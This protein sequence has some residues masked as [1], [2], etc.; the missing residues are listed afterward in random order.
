MASAPSSSTLESPG[1]IQPVTLRD[2]VDNVPAISCA[3]LE[4]PLMLMDKGKAPLRDSQL[5]GP[6]THPGLCSVTNVAHTSALGDPTLGGFRAH[7]A[8]S[9]ALGVP[10][11]AKVT[12]DRALYNPKSRLTVLS[13]IAPDRITD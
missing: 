13:A 9:I 6:S 1:R 4:P 2:D 10:L 7:P 3:P 8:V 5:A 11:L 12:L